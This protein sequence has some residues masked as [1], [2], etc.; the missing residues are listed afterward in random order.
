MGDNFL[1]SEELRLSPLED[2]LIVHKFI[3][4][5]L[6]KIEVELFRAK[7]FDYRHVTPLGATWRYIDIYGTVYR[8]FY[9]MR[10]DKRSAEFITVPTA[11]SVRE[12]LSQNVPKTI[13]SFSSFWRGRQVADAIGMPYTEFLFNAFEARLSYW[14]QAFLPN[15]AHMFGEMVAEKCQEKWLESQKTR[16]FLSDDPAYL[17]QNYQNTD[18]QNDYHEW[19]FT[20]A[21]LR[22]QTPQLLA[23]FIND[24]LLHIDK[25]GGRV[26]GAMM[27]QIRNY[28]E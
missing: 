14:S 22:T 10:R 9:R 6:Q 20:Q 2:D 8:D 5:S 25:V 1:D 27:D 16:L 4:P 7:W 26:G 19:L 3:K 18:A 24:D 17:I 12:G 21:S 15:S 11:D 28:L 23:R 13:K